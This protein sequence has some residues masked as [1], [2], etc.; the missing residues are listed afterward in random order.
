MGLDMYLS[1]RVYIGAHYEH[2]KVKGIIDITAD[3]KH[4]KIK[5][6]RVSEIT[7]QVGYWR[8]AN[9]I[10]NWFVKNVQDGKDNCDEYY[11][12]EEKL[13]Q[14][15]DDCK[16]VR[17]N[18]SIAAEVMPTKKGFFFG[19]TEYD[20]YYMQDISG[21]IEIIETLFK[22]KGDEKYFNGTIYYTSSW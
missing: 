13:Q 6:D 14:L 18:Q 1:K 16:K 12:S 21:T 5:F 3:D 17:D 19:G 10:H 2:R 20:E 7:E 22:E 9:Q 11:V 15:L 8:K 4:I